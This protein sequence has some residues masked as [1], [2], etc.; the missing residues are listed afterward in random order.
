MIFEN[1]W[2]RITEWFKDR[3]ERGKLVR[4]F[5]EA[6]RFAFVTGAAP[7]ALKATISRGDSAYKHEFSAWLNTFVKTRKKKRF[8]TGDRQ[9]TYNQITY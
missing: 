1:A 6:A 5:N 8:S 7:T 3:S 9:I 4:A 2:N